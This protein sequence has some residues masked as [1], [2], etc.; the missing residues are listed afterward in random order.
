MEINGTNSL[1]V[2]KNVAQRIEFP[3]RSETTLKKGGEPSD[4][5]QVELSVRSQSISH[6]NELIQSIPEVREYVVEKVRQ[7]LE[8]GTYDVKAEE[9]AEKLL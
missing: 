4:S 2:A 7:Q 3:Q 6:L 1:M 9:I 5:D 8:N